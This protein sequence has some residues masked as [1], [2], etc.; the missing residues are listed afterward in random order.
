M[1]VMIGSAVWTIL[2]TF[3]GPALLAPSRWQARYPRAALLVWHILFTSGLA[4]LALAFLTAVLLAIC[5]QDGTGRLGAALVVAG[6]VAGFGYT[7]GV[8]LAGAGEISRNELRTRTRILQTPH[9]MRTLDAS[10]DLL[11]SDLAMPF[12]CSFP[13]RRQTVVVSQGLVDSLTAAQL[14]AVVAHERAH[15]TQK[16]FVALRLADLNAACLPMV[17]AARRMRRATGLLIELM[18]DDAAAR[19]AG[20][21]HL[22]N[23][24]VRI[25]YATQDPSLAVRAERLAVRR[26]R[27]VPLANRPV[28]VLP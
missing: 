10:T 25:G 24:L 1:I 26:W 11:L 21:S 20:P 14:A 22:A 16:H 8:V 5:D 6:C 17:P 4:A 19:A 7:T 23:A 13:G 15:L 27:R 9:R 2:V 18:A 3:V 12:A 28:V